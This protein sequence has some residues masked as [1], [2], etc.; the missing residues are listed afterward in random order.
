M[1]RKNSL[2]SAAS[3]RWNTAADFTAA[4]ASCFIYLFCSCFLWFLF[5]SQSA[6]HH[7][8]FLTFSTGRS[9]HSAGHMC[10]PQICT[11]GALGRRVD[12]C[13]RIYAQNVPQAVSLAS[14]VPSG[15]CHC[16]TH[17]SQISAITQA[18]PPPPE[19]TSGLSPCRCAG[20]C[21]V[22]PA[23]LPLSV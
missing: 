5:L 12:Q 7:V 19:E 6:L 17:I 2:V 4:Q 21:Q 14:R 18:T 16:L 3:A 10:S 8:L 22:R 15:K 11:P 9:F 23:F 13:P 1:Q 20:S